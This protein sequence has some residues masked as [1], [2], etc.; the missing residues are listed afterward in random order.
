M[1][2]LITGYGGGGGYGG[3]G[4]YGG[5][6]SILSIPIV[7]GGGGGNNFVGQY[8][9]VYCNDYGRYGYGQRVYSGGYTYGRCY[10]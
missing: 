7:V 6:G 3:Y 10:Y 5:L 4:S 8:P 2:Q 9:W 1:Q